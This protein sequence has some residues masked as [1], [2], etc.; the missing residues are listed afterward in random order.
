[1]NC[2]FQKTGQPL[3]IEQISYIGLYPAFIQANCISSSSFKPRKNSGT[4]DVPL[5]V[6][7]RLMDELGHSQ[8]LIRL[9][10]RFEE[11]GGV[12]FRGFGQNAMTQIEDVTAI[13]GFADGVDDAIANQ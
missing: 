5:F 8:Q 13:S 6:S 1:M 10:G 4:F 2:A 11:E 9:L 3:S 7:Y 12:I